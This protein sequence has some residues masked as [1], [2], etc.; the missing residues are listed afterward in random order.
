MVYFFHGRAIS[1][2]CLVEF[3]WK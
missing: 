2:A 3:L 1:R